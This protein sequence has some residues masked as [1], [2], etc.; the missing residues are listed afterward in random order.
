MQ[1][2]FVALVFLIAPGCGANLRAA[3]S[4]EIGCPESEIEISED[5][6]GG[7]SRTWIAECR[8]RVFYCSAHATGDSGQY[9]CTESLSDVEGAS[10]RAE[11]EGPSESSAPAEAP[12]AKPVESA[13]PTE[14]VG[15]LLSQSPTDA[16]QSCT[17]A[18]HEWSPSGTAF[19]CS[20]T[21]KP[22]VDGA[23]ARLAFCADQLCDLTVF[24]GFRGD[25]ANADSQL[26]SIVSAM[27]D[28][29]GAPRVNV[30]GGTAYCRSQGMIRCTASGGASLT[31]AWQWSSG[32]KIFLAL[33]GKEGSAT[34]AVRYVTPKTSESGASAF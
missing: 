24:L 15:F 28:K 30:K 4:G 23:T 14:A 10:A 22:V 16:E 13:P 19:T 32:E 3:S 11:S 8:G 21:P 18:G 25:D 1:R 2:L 31:Q 29:Y 20:G 26:N 7:G 6:G 17:G 5:S 27:R 12:P 33:K 34:L 9:K